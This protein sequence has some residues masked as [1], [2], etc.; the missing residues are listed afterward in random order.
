MRI[1]GRKTIEE[2]INTCVVVLKREGG[3]KGEWWGER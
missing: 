1:Q 3:G 2:V